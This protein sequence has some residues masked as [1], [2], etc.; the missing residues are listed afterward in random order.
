MLSQGCNSQSGRSGQGKRPLGSQAFQPKENKRHLQDFGQ[1]DPGSRG[2]PGLGQGQAG[3]KPWF[4]CWLSRVFS[5]YMGACEADKDFPLPEKSHAM[6]RKQPSPSQV[7]NYPPQDKGGALNL[8]GRG[9]ENK[10]PK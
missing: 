3:L 7:L 8:L 1:L 10:D 5:E 9:V 4:S 6:S 2:R